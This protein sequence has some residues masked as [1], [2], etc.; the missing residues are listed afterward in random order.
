MNAPDNPQPQPPREGAA[1]QSRPARR[2]PARKDTGWLK[3]LLATSGLA[4]TIIGSG[5]IA[6]RDAS[7]AAVAPAEATT[8]TLTLTLDPVPTAAAP[9][10]ASGVTLDA[11]SSRPARLV[12]PGA[13]TLSRSSR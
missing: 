6:R 2:A 4:L 5:L 12:F 9:S 10:A 1:R 8:P 13:M 7:S 11:G 3:A